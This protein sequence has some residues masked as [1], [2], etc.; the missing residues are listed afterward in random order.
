MAI[1]GNATTAEG[2]PADFVRIFSWPTSELVGV[3]IPDESGDWSHEVPLTGDYGLTYIA[4]GCQPI[5]HGPYYVEAQFT[6]AWLFLNEEPGLWYETTDVGTLTLN[7][8]GTGVVESGDAVG[9]LKD[10]SGNGNHATQ[11]FTNMRPIYPGLTYD[12]TD[13][14]LLL[15]DGLGNTSDV[16]VCG[17][18][19]MIN[20][21]G[22]HDVFEFSSTDGTT[23]FRVLFYQGDWWFQVGTGGSNGRVSI[24]ASNTPPE[25]VLTLTFS[26]GI[27][28]ARVNG[29]QV[30]Q[31]TVSGYNPSSGTSYIGASKADNGPKNHMV[32]EVGALVAVHRNV[33]QTEI[34]ETEKY[35]ARLHGLTL[36]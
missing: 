4:A 32:G 11:S 2:L 6:P 28:T 16:F 36:P 27:F 10:K 33:T 18:A 22:Q 25:A 20:P 31:T 9:M 24:I 3:A 7:S 26:G 14:Y 23:G 29:I 30:G 8:G 21:T 5:T 17:Y 12:G 34:E 13:D 15:P 1:S 19:K 35:I